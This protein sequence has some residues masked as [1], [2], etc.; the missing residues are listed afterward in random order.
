M[1]LSLSYDYVLSL[2]VQTLRPYKRG[3]MKAVSLLK[4]PVKLEL[5]SLDSPLRLLWCHIKRDFVGSVWIFR[6]EDLQMRF[7]VIAAAKANDEL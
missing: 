2:V 7:S 5:F 6:P 4:I 3:L 1:P